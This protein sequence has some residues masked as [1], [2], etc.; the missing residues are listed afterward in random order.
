MVHASE[1]PNEA[2]PLLWPA[3]NETESGPESSARWWNRNAGALPTAFLVAWVIGLNEGYIMNINTT[4]IGK[5]LNKMQ[6]GVLIIL[7]PRV[8][9]AIVP[10]LV[11]FLRRHFSG[12]SS[13][14]IG[15]VTVAFGLFGSFAA[16]SWCLLWPLL[17]AQSVSSCG[18]GLLNLLTLLVVREAATDPRDFPKYRAWYTSFM[19]FGKAAGALGGTALIEYSGPARLPKHGQP[20][21]TPFLVAFGFA[22]TL[23]GV[24]YLS[25]SQGRLEDESSAGTVCLD[26]VET[27]LISLFTITPIALCGVLVRWGIRV[28]YLAIALPLMI[29]FLFAIGL[30]RWLRGTKTLYSAKVISSNP[31]LLVL[32]RA[33]LSAVVQTLL[34]RLP[35]HA[36]IS[37]MMETEPDKQD[38]HRGHGSR[39]QA[40][41]GNV[42]IPDFKQ[43][44]MLPVY[45]VGQLAGEAIA[46]AG[47]HIVGHE[48]IPLGIS[49]SVYFV[50]VQLLG[51]GA[52]GHL[53]GAHWGQKLAS[54][55]I[56]MTL[57]AGIA[58]GSADN[59]L[60]SFLFAAVDGADRPAAETLSSLASNIMGPV[61]V[62]F[63]SLRYEALLKN[64][65]VC[66][67][68]QEE[69][70]RVAKTVLNNISAVDG[71]SN[72]QRDVILRYARK[73]VERNIWEIDYGLLVG[74]VTALVLS[75][76]D[77]AG[78]AAQLFRW[79]SSRANYWIE[80][81]PES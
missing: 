68:G 60:S 44:V 58:N 66:K 35:L 31:I 78:P 30:I 33:T 80:A 32:A 43:N 38:L 17:L 6:Q 46:A 70:H 40:C 8:P 39:S 29:V 51:N 59:C 10:P 63:A 36:Q 23:V 25:P 4:Y 34:Y 41:N 52:I 24:I 13:M 12:R 37:T 73:A 2:A 64:D 15:A 3:A 22:V 79:A 19:M 48:A 77:S 16:G 57:L 11:P 56:I 71:F 74:I 18:I 54:V 69:G 81:G 27:G 55:P 9:S 45:Y 62:A 7:L 14:L 61:A 1:P 28:G 47:I 67:Y 65:L 76:K 26:W 20:W 53:S 50:V 42:H 21:Q 72:D 49:L 75:W 5:G